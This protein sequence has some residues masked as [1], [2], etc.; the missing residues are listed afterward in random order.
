M[1][2]V[3]VLGAGNQGAV[4]ARTLSS[5][6]S[7]EQVTVVDMNDEKLRRLASVPR[8]VTV[9][10]DVRDK[11]FD[12]LL[13]SCDLV[14]GALPSELGFYAMKEAIDAGVNMVDTSFMPENPLVL[15]ELAQ[16]SDASIVPDCGVAP[17][18]SHILIGHYLSQLTRAEEIHIMVGGLPQAPK[19]P[20]GYVVTWSARDLIEEY[21]R[22]ARVVR[23]NSIVSVDPFSE[24]AP[25]DLPALGRLESFYTD[26][27]RT[28]LHTVRSVDSMDERTLRY[29]GHVEKVKVLRD[30]GLFSQELVSIGSCK[31]SPRDVTAEVLSRML[32]G[33][34]ERDVTVLVVRVSGMKTGRRMTFEGQV[35]DYYDERTQFSSMARTTGFT[36]V[37][38][39][40]LLLKGQ[41]KEKGVIPPEILGMNPDYFG[42]IVGYLRGRGIQIAEM[43]E[44]TD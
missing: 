15:D 33:E 7:I 8:T 29:P 30:C 42:E 5:D 20:L 23:E 37:A 19:P 34:N 13:S 1:R 38:V 6:S 28:L 11:K 12:A 44:Y 10:T 39:C 9:Q 36:N 21:T 41:L 3:L 18:L 22:P 40:N 26:G 25:V 31:V 14:S 35:V 16:K 27:L 2:R 17:G 24:T 32:S 4:I 43:R